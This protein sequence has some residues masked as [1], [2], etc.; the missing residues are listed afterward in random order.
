MNITLLDYSQVSNNDTSKAHV[1]DFDAVVKLQ[2]RNLV[3]K[4][5]L[6]SFQNTSAG[7]RVAKYDTEYFNYWNGWVFVDIDHIE[8]DTQEMIEMLHEKLQRFPIYKAAQRSNGEQ[9][10]HIYFYIE[11]YW[12]TVEEYYAFAVLCYNIVFSY[13]DTKYFDEHNFIHSQVFK[14]SKRQWY[15]NDNFSINDG[16]YMVQTS[17]NMNEYC[18][19][20]R[21]MYPLRLKSFIKEADKAISEYHNGGKITIAPERSTFTYKVNGEFKPVEGLKKFHLN[22]QERYGVICALMNFYG[23]DKNKA[24][25][26]YSSI[27]DYHLDGKH[28]NNWYKHEYDNIDENKQYVAIPKWVKWLET[29]FNITVQ[30]F[31]ADKVIELNGKDDYL[32]L[33]KDEVI[34]NLKVGVNMI[35]AGTGTGK[36]EFWKSLN[37]EIY[38]DIFAT[39]ELPILVVEPYNSIIDGKYN[40]NEINKI[41]GSYHFPKEA[42]NNMMYVT[43]YNH[44]NSDIKDDEDW[45]RFRYI[46]IDESHLLTKEYFRANTL[47]KFINRI[48]DIAKSSIVI[49]QTGTPMDEVKLFEDINTIQV[50]KKDPRNITYKF[51][52]YDRDANNNRPFNINYISDLTNNLVNEG[53][54]VYVYWN[55][56]SLTNCKA[57]QQYN[58]NLNIAI[59]HK[60]H[61][62]EYTCVTNKDMM[63]I[64]TEH[65]LGD[66]LERKY[67]VLISSVY[68]GVG[69][70]LNDTDDTAVIII[71][72]NAWQEDIQCIGR[73]RK[74][75]N[76]E[77]YCILTD[78]KYV[79]SIED[80]YDRMIGYKETNIRYNYNDKTNRDKSITIHRKCFQIENEED[81]RLYALMSVC[82]QYNSTLEYKYVKLS[83]YG[84]KVDDEIGLLE[85]NALDVERQKLIKKMLSEVRDTYKLDTLTDLINEGKILKWHNND[86]KV[87]RWQKIVNRIYNIDNDVFLKLIENKFINKISNTDSMSLF[88]SLV[89]KI[90]LNELDAPEVEAWK[91]Y[92][93]IIREELEKGSKIDEGVHGSSITFR[94]LTAATAY[95]Y[96]VHYKNSG[97]KDYGILGDYFEAFYHNAESFLRMSNEMVEYLYYIRS[98][99]ALEAQYEKVN[100]EMD[101]LGLEKIDVAELYQC[102]PFETEKYVERS[103]I[104]VKS[105]EK[106][107]LNE[108]LERLKNKHLNAGRKGK[109][110]VVDGIVYKSQSDFAVKNKMSRQAANK[111][112]KKMGLI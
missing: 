69:N 51:L 65:V 48:K 39:H 78:D 7:F 102:N 77:V 94:E 11:P 17:R 27:M 66:G 56:V 85:F 74:S 104:F 53:K 110:I 112:L 35:I 31:N 41:T 95:I 58:F 91:W 34:S 96:F 50:I 106:T 40:P 47:T 10:I 73:W 19:N 88:C 8:T 108:L 24:L 100:I 22:H 32:F 9:G 107:C 45:T 38:N 61:L 36:T 28:D 15:V 18:N 109:E 43:N 111:K 62:G 12:H 87:E 25:S 63:W 70:D 83:E 86:S 4:Q 101:V 81:I 46:V 98:E 44:I 99:R 3:E 37:K 84:I 76:I 54:K 29:N 103:H 90:E 55:N 30:T 21:N 1:V 16:Q 23:N 60:R 52:K 82:E 105:S 93:K 33:H 2:V 92:S 6:P 26:V 68:F 49:L 71:G 14:I 72:N 64:D 59:Y 42:V 89:D 79:W 75:P 20:L 67:D 97:T 80:E 57:F 5:W 13:I